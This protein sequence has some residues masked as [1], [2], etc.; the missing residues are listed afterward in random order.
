[1]E[2]SDLKYI[3]LM[4]V[5]SQADETLD[6]TL[7]KIVARKSKEEIEAGR[8]FWG[9]GGTVCNPFK[10]VHPFAQIAQQAGERLLLVMVKTPSHFESWR[11]LS[12]AY[13]ID[14]A[15]KIWQPIPEGIT[16]RGS[17]HAIVCKNL[18][19]VS[20]LK[21]NLSAYKVGVGD[22]K[23]T[24]LK[25]YFRG[26]VDKACAYLSETE[27]A[28]TDYDP[29]IEVAYIADVIEPYAVMLR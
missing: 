20:S 9:Y 5:G 14:H 6:E 19:T 17:Q 4:K 23:D 15:K 21:L 12:N 3:V 1:M 7:E 27:I 2:S 18:R 16:I 28:Q 10:Q 22:R 11:G 26:R 25:D 13:S 29:L 24:P 8:I